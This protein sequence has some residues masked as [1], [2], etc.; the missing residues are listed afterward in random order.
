MLPT[1]SVSDLLIDSACFKSSVK[2][3]A[4]TRYLSIFL[5]TKITHCLSYNVTLIALA[6]I[7][8]LLVVSM[9]NTSFL[10]L[11]MNFYVPVNPVRR[12]AFPLGLRVDIKMSFIEYRY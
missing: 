11:L 5:L 8:L 4:Y 6:D 12:C 3:R 7:I 9:P 1:F 10:L 2:V